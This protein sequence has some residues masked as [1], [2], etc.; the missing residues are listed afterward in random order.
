MAIESHPKWYR[1]VTP[2]KCL[3][4]GSFPPH[5]SKW[6]YPFY[7]P[8]SINRFWKILSDISC[9]PLQYAKKS[10]IKTKEAKCKAVEERFQIMRSLNI[11]V[12]NVGKIIERK[13]RSSLDSDIKI[14]EFQNILSI[15]ESH[16][17]LKRILLAGYSA[18]NSTAKSFLK[19][20]SI[21]NI[22]Y[23]IDGICPEKKFFINAFNRK[24][25][26]VILNSTS[27][28]AKIKYEELLKQFKKNLS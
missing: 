12:Q 24:I 20:L 6:D 28:A 9:K 19:Y 23:K 8:N 5:E 2:M 16:K 22:P 3:I 26:C 27:T 25:E 17:E 4:L 13:G 10:E 1:D 15:I 7:Y 14:K 21:N 11:G 18:S